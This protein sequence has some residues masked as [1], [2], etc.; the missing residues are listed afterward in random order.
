MRLIGLLATHLALGFV[1]LCGLFALVIGKY[2][3]FDPGEPPAVDDAAVV[4][5]IAWFVAAGIAIWQWSTHRRYSFVTPLSWA[6]LA[7]A[8]SIAVVAA[9]PAAVPGPGSYGP[10]G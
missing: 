10:S 1:W 5:V 8:L 6:G 2:G 4:A 3:L 7:W 9:S